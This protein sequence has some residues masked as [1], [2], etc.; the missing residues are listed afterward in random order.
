MGIKMNKKSW[1]YMIMFVLC[2][3]VLVNNLVVLPATFA[4]SGREFTQP[5]SL[6][7]LLLVGFLF[8]PILLG[9][10]RHKG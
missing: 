8:F 9:L 1:F 10:E 3:A 4:E 6:N 7:A 5:R 2:C